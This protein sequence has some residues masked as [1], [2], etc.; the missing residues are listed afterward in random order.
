MKT[1]ISHGLLLMFILNILFG[2]RTSSS[3]DTWIAM[4]RATK[5]GRII[6]TKN[7]DRTVFD[8]QPLL[9]YGRKKWDDHAMIDLGRLSIPQVPETY[10][11]IGSSPYWCW[12]FEEGMNE[13]GVTIGNEGIMTKSLQEEIRRKNM[14]EMQPYGPTGMDILR[15][16]LE[17]SKTAAEAVQVIGYM[18]ETYGQFGSGLP[19]TDLKGAYHNSYM[20]ADP[21]EAW[22]VETTGKHWVARHVTEDV[23]SISNTFSITDRWDLASEGLIRN[24]VRRGWWDKSSDK[25]DFSDVYSDDQPV[26]L[27]LQ[28][29]AGIRANCSLGLLHQKA[30]DID[31]SWMMRIA[32]DRST[33]P[34]LDLDVTASSCIAVLPGNDD[35]LPVFWW[36]ASVPGISCYI[37]YFVQSGK[38]PSVVS[39]A[40]TR[41]KTVTP[42]R[43]VAM[44]QF[45][46]DSF[47]WLFRDLADK[48]NLNWDERHK[49]IRSEFDLL[50]HEF[51]A[52]AKTVSKKAALLINSGSEA[53]ASGILSS[54]TEKCLN[55]VIKKL[56]EL[57][58]LFENEVPDIDVSEFKDYIGTYEIRK[59]LNFDISLVGEQLFARLTGQPAFE[60]YPVYKDRFEFRVAKAAIKFVRNSKD[61]VTTLL[62]F[63]GGKEIPA[64]RVPSGPGK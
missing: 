16:A 61:E 3:C 14:G 42:P 56:N 51:M 53:E 25:F 62:L 11:V 38:L 54:F 50:E 13:F 63:Q 2:T 29:R 8:S 5:D 9:L 32:R 35:E 33:T 20:V 48:A 36:A 18:T 37:P 39:K 1:R 22:I 59:G 34:G 4:K 64:K 21:V 26:Y 45:S 12:G 23:A 40:G 57:R 58:L 44:D 55:K 15:L 46:E 47:W 27:A 28:R 17:R 24:A 7:S 19:A 41:G 49:L 60:V 43:K 52:E 6:F 10:A 30:P 31:E